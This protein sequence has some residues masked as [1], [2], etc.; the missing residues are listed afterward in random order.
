MNYT[1]KKSAKK[2]AGV[3]YLGGIATSYK[4]A[5]SL[6]YGVATYVLYLAPWKSAGYT[7]QGKQI[8]TCAKA[9]S[10]CISGCLNT[11]GQARLREEVNNARIIRTRLFY[12]NRDF[13]MD[14]LIAEIETA[15][16]LAAK[17]MQKFAVR[18]N[19]TSDLSPELFKRNGKNILEIFP[20]VQFYDYTKV[21]NRSA[22]LAK[23][24]N[25]HLTFSYSGENWSECEA[26]LKTGG[27]AAIVFNVRRKKALPAMYKGF[28]IID[29]DLHDY[30]P[31][32]GNR[33]LVGL[34]WKE[35]K[36]RKVNKELKETSRFVIR[37]ES[38]T[39]VN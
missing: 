35:I 24:K 19:G 22:L 2:Q 13:F 17:K 7:S 38:N 30:R 11:A 36:D 27:N 15:K 26:F 16:K 37:I 34:R 20:D 12:N 1:N 39:F 31:L 33:I 32:D 3:T 8:N 10:E 29:G 18:L 23:Y 21:F 9:T 14:W 25:Y 28:N 6:Q 5:K 4:I